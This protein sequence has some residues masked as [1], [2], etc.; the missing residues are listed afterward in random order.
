[1][2]HK[3]TLITVEVFISFPERLFEFLP[4]QTLSMELVASLIEFLA[5]PL[6]FKVEISMRPKS[7]HRPMR[8]EPSMLA[9]NSSRATVD[10]WP[11]HLGTNT[12]R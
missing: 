11:D 4:R 3:I 7:F 2:F 8:A 5:R 12:T 6:S 1:V 10:S 9:K